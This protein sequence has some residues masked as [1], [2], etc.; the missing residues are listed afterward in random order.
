RQCKAIQTALSKYNKAASELNSPRP[1]LDW[2]EVLHYGSLEEFTLLCE[3]RQDV[4]SKPA[5]CEAIK[6]SHQLNHTREELNRC[7]VE[8]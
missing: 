5:T 6:Q 3:T 8:S 2:S 1:E 7:N 4:L